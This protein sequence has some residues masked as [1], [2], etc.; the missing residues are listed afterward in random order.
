[1]SAKKASTQAQN[2][3]PRTAQTHQIVTLELVTR[4]APTLGQIE[5]MCIAFGLGPIGEEDYNFTREETEEL[6]GRHGQTLTQQHVSETAVRIHLQRIVGA[7]VQSAFGA[8]TFYG[9]KVSEARDLTTK[10]GNEDRDE[11][12]QGVAGFESKAAR[13]RS[14]AAQAGLTAFTLLAAATGAVHAYAEVTGEDWKPYVPA[15]IPAASISRDSAA[16]ELDAL[17]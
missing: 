9:N 2:S 6:I 10:L 8:A 11:D 12:S 13:A 4:L 15:Q 17:G 3:A 1:M 14:F 5:R 16:A 7:F